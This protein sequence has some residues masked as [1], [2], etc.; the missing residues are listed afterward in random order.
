M[1]VILGYHYISVRT[2]T[3]RWGL[4]VC[5]SASCMGRFQR[6]HGRC[7]TVQPKIRR[8]VK[9][10]AVHLCPNGF[11][12]IKSSQRAKICIG[13]IFGTCLYRRCIDHTVTFFAGTQ[14]QTNP[15]HFLFKVF[16]FPYRHSGI[17]EMR[18]FGMLPATNTDSIISQSTNLNPFVVDDKLR[19]R[20]AYLE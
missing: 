10:A 17:F 8:T 13:T 4:R 18:D 19:V 9:L 5:Q 7:G 6:H 12:L 16:L 3:P 11:S 20:A 1:Y 2:V 15:K 14:K